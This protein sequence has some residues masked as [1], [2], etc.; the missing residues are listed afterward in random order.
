MKKIFLSVATVIVTRFI[1]KVVN[2]VKNPPVPTREELLHEE[3]L[4]KKREYEQR[5]QDYELRRGAQPKVDVR[6]ASTP[7]SADAWM[8]SIGTIGE[9]AAQYKQN[10]PEPKEP[11]DRAALRPRADMG[12]RAWG[13]SCDGAAMGVAR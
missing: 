2:R 3:I 13:G 6:F 11:C 7:R 10:I 1:M 4:R 8:A 12:L 5:R 9:M